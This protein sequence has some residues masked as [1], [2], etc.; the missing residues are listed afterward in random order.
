MPNIASNETQSFDLTGSWV[1]KEHCHLTFR[2]NEDGSGDTEIDY[3]FDLYDLVF[4]RDVLSEFI[5]SS[6]KE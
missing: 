3:L 6:P 2:L 5:D 1:N 4:L